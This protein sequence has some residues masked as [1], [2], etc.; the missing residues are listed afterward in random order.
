MIMRNVGKA[1]NDKFR[2][3]KIIEN[4]IFYNVIKKVFYE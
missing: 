1:R 4:M 2:F 3:Q